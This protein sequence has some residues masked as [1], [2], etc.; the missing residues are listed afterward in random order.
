[1]GIFML[2][3]AITLILLFIDITMPTV[4]YNETDRL[5]ERELMRY[6]RRGTH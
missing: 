4:R 6:Q 1:M 2:L 3:A 5:H